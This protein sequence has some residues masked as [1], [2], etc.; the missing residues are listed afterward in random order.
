MPLNTRVGRCVTKL[1][2]KYGY[3][4]A[5][6][7]CQHSTKQN[8]LTGKTMR[9]KKTS[10]RKKR[11][12]RKK[13]KGGASKPDHIAIDIKDIEHGDARPPVEPQRVDADGIHV[14]SNV[15]VIDGDSPNLDDTGLVVA[16]NNDELASIDVYL[17][18]ADEEESFRPDQLELIREGGMRPLP[19]LTI[20]THMGTKYMMK[21]DDN[22]EPVLNHK[23]MIELYDYKRALES[24]GNMLLRKKQIPS[25]K[26]PQ[27]G[28][29]KKTRRRKKRG[30]THAPT[31]IIKAT[32]KP[33]ADFTKKI[34]NNPK[35]VSV[36]DE[37][38]RE[39]MNYLTS[40][41][42]DNTDDNRYFIMKYEEGLWYPGEEISYDNAVNQC[43]N[44]CYQVDSTGIRHVLKR[45]VSHGSK[46]KTRKKRRKKS[47]RR[48]K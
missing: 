39:I 31:W 42:K 15:K 47:R 32:P 9:K 13:K 3:G 4:K 12:G 37:E 24:R 29:G 20:K 28:S 1:R 44:P 5:I 36:E 2:K 7:I 46:H 43:S 27:E 26:N 25:Y 8:Y 10:R 11:G 48:R 40:E 21:V 34:F 45:N 16:I 38:A 33:V 35:Y 6:G 41:A 30:G 22:N 17:D 14:G 19:S 18:H 23:G